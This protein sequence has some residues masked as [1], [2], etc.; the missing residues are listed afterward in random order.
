MAEQF[1]TWQL[2]SH[3][4]QHSTLV[5]TELDRQSERPNL[6]NQ[7]VMSALFWICIKIQ[8]RTMAIWSIMLWKDLEPFLYL[9]K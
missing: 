9:G 7:L 8:M 4:L 3:D 5:L 2:K 1:V 6:I